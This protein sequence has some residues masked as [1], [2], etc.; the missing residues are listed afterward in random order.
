[1]SSRENE[2]RGWKKIRR[3][4]GEAK[5]REK[6][7]FRILM[8]NIR[9]CIEKDR[10]LRTELFEVCRKTNRKKLEILTEASEYIKRKDKQLYD[11]MSDSN[12]SKTERD[13]IR[14]QF[15]I[16]EYFMRLAGAVG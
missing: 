2:K 8:K 10:K 6:E 3:D 16:K 4:V 5:V 11:K 7:I 15:F 9:V 12:T 1:M 13:W 14:F